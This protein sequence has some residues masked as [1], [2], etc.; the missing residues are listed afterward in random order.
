MKKKYYIFELR[1]LLDDNVLTVLEFGE[2][3]G[4]ARNTL[5]KALTGD[6]NSISKNTLKKI[7]AFF[8]MDLNR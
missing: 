8:D 5:Y 4:I 1:Q 3:T 6:W 2:K 7:A